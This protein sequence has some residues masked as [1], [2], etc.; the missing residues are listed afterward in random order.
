MLFDLEKTNK[1]DT[2]IKLVSLTFFIEPYKK[3]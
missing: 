3:S 2:E 1:S